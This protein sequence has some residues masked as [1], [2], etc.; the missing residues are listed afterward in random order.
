MD[1]PDDSISPAARYS[2]AAM[3]FVDVFLKI[4]VFISILQ[5]N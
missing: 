2:D 1:R 5:V 4:Q 3:D